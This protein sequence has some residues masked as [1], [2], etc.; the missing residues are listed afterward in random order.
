MKEGSVIV[1]KTGAAQFAEASREARST[2]W[3]AC[4]G[5]GPSEYGELKIHFQ[6][7]P[8]SKNV[9]RVRRGDRGVV[10]TAG[11]FRVCLFARV[12][13]LGRAT[14]GEAVISGSRTRGRSIKDATRAQARTARDGLR[15]WKF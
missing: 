14:C 9:I 11:N 4:D 3:K 8:G 7:D 2:A 13:E 15:V 10:Q 5:R 1:E 6:I 12:E